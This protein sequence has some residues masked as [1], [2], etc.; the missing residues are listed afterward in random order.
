MC[1]RDRAYK[2][3][4]VF[5]TRSLTSSQSDLLPAAPQPHRRM[6][7]IEPKDWDP[8]PTF[9]YELPLFSGLLEESA[10][11]EAVPDIAR[12]WEMLD[13]GRI[14]V[15]HLRDDVRWSDGHPVTAD[16]FE[17]AWK[18]LLDPTGAPMNARKRSLDTSTGLRAA[19]PLHDVQ[20]AQTYHAGRSADPDSVGVHAV[21]PMTL[22]IELERP[23]A[24]WPHIMA[25]PATFPVPKHR[26]EQYGDPL[27][28]I[29]I[30]EPTRPY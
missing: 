13:G 5:W 12:S 15:F 23:V 14:Y 22:V 9:D 1:I 30:S 10:D 19:G 3:S 16:D 2:E 18:R 24:Y 26:V 4:F 25:N 20:G 29:H 6:W 17:F 27:S 7:G 8:N 21:D 11:L 28:L